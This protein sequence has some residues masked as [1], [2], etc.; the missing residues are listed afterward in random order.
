MSYWKEFVSCVSMLEGA[1]TNEKNK[2]RNTSCSAPKLSPVLVSL[3]LPPPDRVALA[4]Y[5]PFCFPSQILGS[6]PKGFESLHG[7]G[8]S[9]LPPVQRS[10]AGRRWWDGPCAAPQRALALQLQ[11][12][13]QQQ[14]LLKLGLVVPLFDVQLSSLNN[15]S[16]KTARIGYGEGEQG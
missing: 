8:P 3:S 9:P 6:A 5:L 15:V 11:E 7:M 2:P 10:C 13:R 4:D 12:P 16:L 1:L 14:A